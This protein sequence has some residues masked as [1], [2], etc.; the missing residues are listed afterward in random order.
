[1]TVQTKGEKTR[2]RV[3]RE[4]RKLIVG[5]GFNNTSINEII[6]ATGV[7][8]GAMYFH[9]A[10]KEE[11]GFSVLLDAKEEFFDFLEASFI[12]ESPHEKID[13]FFLSLLKQQQNV[14]FVGGC[15]FGN[16]ALEMSDS[17]E[18]YANL[19]KEIFSDWTNILT[20]LLKEAQLGGQVIGTIDAE[21]LAHTIVATLEGGIMMARVSKKSSNL[22]DCIDVIR[23]LI[24]V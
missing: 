15:L 6:A 8:K 17:N 18:R 24:T 12:G 2:T 22:A 21:A 14:H 11:L 1:M 4:A 9:F 16:T 19:I 23:S 10:N 20:R 3:I 7:K 5:K 13:H